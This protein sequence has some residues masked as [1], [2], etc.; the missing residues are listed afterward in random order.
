[1]NLAKQHRHGDQESDNLQRISRLA[2]DEIMVSQKQNGIVTK[3]LMF[4]NA[5]QPSHTFKLAINI[6]SYDKI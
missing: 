1:M 4:N 6:L 2:G 5:T 3:M